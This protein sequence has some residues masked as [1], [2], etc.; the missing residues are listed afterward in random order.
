MEDKLK[1]YAVEIK[2]LSRSITKNFRK[3]II[4]QLSECNFTV[5]QLTV[6][7][8]L[9][10]HSGITLKELSERI[11]LSKST[12]CGIVDRLE[13][14][15]AVIRSRGEDDRRN[16]QLFLAPEM[17][18]FKDTM[19]G[20]KDTYMAEILKKADPSDVENL[21]HILKKFNELIEEENKGV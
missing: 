15:E 13:A 9:H 8:E 19:N 6:M 21:V 4:S 12:V 11:G 7:Q 10:S 2:S 16:V 14:Q 3:Y 5:P 17:M 20:I 18:K 1:E